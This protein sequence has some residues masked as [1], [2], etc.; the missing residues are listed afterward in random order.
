M[1]I[2]IKLKRIVVT[3]NTHELGIKK[4]YIPKHQT[5]LFIILQ[6]RE[7]YKV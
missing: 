3:I 5:I 7:N 1:K 2:E 4:N 6:I